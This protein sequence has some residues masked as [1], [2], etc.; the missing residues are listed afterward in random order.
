VVVAGSS[1]KAFGAAEI[2]GDKFG[3]S[4][5]YRLD[6]REAKRRIGGGVARVELDRAPEHAGLVIAFARRMGHELAAA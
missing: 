6:Q 3:P 4:R 2:V 5:R 1:D